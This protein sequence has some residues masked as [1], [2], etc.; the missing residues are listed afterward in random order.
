MHQQYFAAGCLEQLLE[1]GA[2]LSGDRPEGQ[3]AQRLIG[4]G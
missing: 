3:I 2:S 4:R 1:I